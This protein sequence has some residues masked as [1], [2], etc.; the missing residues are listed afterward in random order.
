[1]SEEK[2]NKS[3]NHDQIRLEVNIIDDHPLLN[4][5]LE[6]GSWFAVDSNQRVTK[7]SHCHPNVYKKIWGKPLPRSGGT[8]E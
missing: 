5:F 1:M 3:Y 6:D 4:V 2:N 8:K 7:G